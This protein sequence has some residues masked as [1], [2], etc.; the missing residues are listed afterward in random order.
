MQKRTFTPE[1]KTKVVLEVLKE[2]KTLSEI[3]SYYEIHPNLLG[4]L[5]KYKTE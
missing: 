4:S 5:V 3:A 1:F 2:E